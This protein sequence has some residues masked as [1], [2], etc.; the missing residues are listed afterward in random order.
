IKAQQ[1]HWRAIKRDAHRWQELE[2]EVLDRIE[3]ALSSRETPPHYPCA[4]PDTLDGEPF[5]CVISAN[6]WHVGQVTTPSE[7]SDGGYNIQIAIRRA[8]SCL[9]QHMRHVTER[10]GTP[11][12]WIVPLGD[13]VHA[14]TWQRTTTRGTQVGG[15]PMA[16]QIDASVELAI[17]IVDALRNAADVLC[18]P[19]QGNHDRLS[20]LWLRHTLRA[21]FRNVDGVTIADNTRVNHCVQYGASMLHFSHGDE[22]RKIADL[23][24]R[25]AV[26]FAELWGQCRNRYAFVGHRHHTE[27]KDFAGCRVLQAPS[28]AGRSAWEEL[29]GYRSPHECAAY[30]IGQNSGHVA[31]IWASAK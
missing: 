15:A 21:W 23:P 30:I 19:L 10:Y 17:G 28:L 6:D 13:F 5:V 4:Q 31:Q 9:A 22:V 2:R 26:D 18:V 29:E 25:M 11:S 14:D 1:R 3:R 16:E 27:T 20:S 7:A 24:H 12:R 8:L